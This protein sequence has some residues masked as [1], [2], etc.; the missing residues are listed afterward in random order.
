M[1]DFLGYVV[2]AVVAALVVDALE[3]VSHRAALLMAVTIILLV[4]I[5]RQNVLAGF[6]E[7][8]S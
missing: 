4:L 6:V 2:A 5:A 7:R 8:V 1:R 3:G